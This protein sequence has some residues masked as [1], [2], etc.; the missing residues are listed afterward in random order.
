MNLRSR[1]VGLLRIA[2][3]V[4]IIGC[5]IGILSSFV[6][7]LTVEVFFVLAGASMVRAV[8]RNASA[9]AYALSRMRRLAPEV[10]FVWGMCLLLVLFG[11]AR[12]GVILFLFSVPVFLEN[13][14]KPFF[15]RGTGIDCKFLLALWFVAALV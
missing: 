13:F 6:G 3:A 1:C 12:R 7:H 2:G 8:E 11:P 10:A 15:V 4:A 5:H 14:I 9:S